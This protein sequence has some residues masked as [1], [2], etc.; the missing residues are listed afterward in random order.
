VSCPAGSPLD[1]CPGITRLPRDDQDQAVAILDSLDATVGEGFSLIVD[2]I[3]QLPEGPL[4][5]HLDRLTRDGRRPGATIVASAATEAVGGAFR[6]P[7]AQ[8]RRARCGL[9]L[10]GVA[11]HD[12]ELFGV[13]LPAR[14]GLD[15]PPGRGWLVASGRARRL[16]LADPER[17]P[18]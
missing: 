15:D 10:G 3:D 4:W 13:R 11:R 6:G 9:L 7:V 16:Q 2:D 12:G 8:L 1:R 5:E 18:V 14:S 17:L